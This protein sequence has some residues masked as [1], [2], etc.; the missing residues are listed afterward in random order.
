ML[1]VDASNA[2]DSLYFDLVALGLFSIIIKA[3]Q[4]WLSGI[5]MKTCIVWKVLLRGIPC[6]CFCMLMAHSLCFERESF[7][8]SDMVC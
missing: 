7:V 6:L 2:S 1:L 8:C 3:G 5:P 4:H